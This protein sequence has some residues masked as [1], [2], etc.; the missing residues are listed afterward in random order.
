[1]IYDYVKI[2]TSGTITNKNFIQVLISIKQILENEGIRYTNSHLSLCLYYYIGKLSIPLIQTITPIVNISQ[3]DYHNCEEYLNDHKI[4]SEKKYCDVIY[5]LAGIGALKVGI[6]STARL[7]LFRSQLYQANIFKTIVSQHCCS[8]KPRLLL[9]Y[10]H[11]FCRQR[12]VYSYYL[13]GRLLLEN[14]YYSESVKIFQIG[15]SHGCI[16]CEILVFCNDLLVNNITKSSKRNFN[17]WYKLYR[18]YRMIDISKD[19]NKTIIPQDLVRSA[20]GI[21]QSNFESKLHLHNKPSNVSISLFK[22]YD[23]ILSRL[24]IYE[25][26]LKDDSNDLTEK[27]DRVYDMLI[28]SSTQKNSNKIIYLLTSHAIYLYASGRY[29]LAYYHLKYLVEIVPESQ[30]LYYTFAKCTYILGKDMDSYRKA[31]IPMLHQIVSF[32]KLSLIT[33]IQINKYLSET[34]NNY[35]IT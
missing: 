4:P 21:I 27:I 7:F 26:S 9:K 29:F 30:W 17:C 35:Y 28:P 34:Q 13:L 18:T 31:A 11:L 25:L 5:F 14:N 3:N 32:K 10:Y 12:M 1:M 22:E 6:Y 19:E 33:R 8:L 20:I 2:F 15:A 24:A 23:S 16:L